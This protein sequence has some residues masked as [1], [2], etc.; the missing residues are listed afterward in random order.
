M[1]TEKSRVLELL[2]MLSQPAAPF[3]EDLV[4][5]QV[6]DIFSQYDQSPNVHSRSDRYGNIVWEYWNSPQGKSVCMAMASH[7]DH[8]GF[9]PVESKDNRVKANILGGLFRTNELIGSQVLMIDGQQ[10]YRGSV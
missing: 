6:N 8:P 7:M 4:A 2:D 1:N 9:D 5:A 3:Y 10:E